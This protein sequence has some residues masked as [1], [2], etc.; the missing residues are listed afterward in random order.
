MS[1]HKSIAIDV[2]KERLEALLDKKDLPAVTIQQTNDEG[3]T[4][5][6]LKIPI[7]YNF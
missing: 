1:N 7:E 6:Q 3:G 2:T 5:V 4:E